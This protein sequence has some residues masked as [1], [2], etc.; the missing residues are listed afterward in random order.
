MMSLKSTIKKL[1]KKSQKFIEE[2][3]QLV[4]WLFFFSKNDCVIMIII[5]G[6]SIFDQT[7]H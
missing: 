3:N 2:T 6:I 7:K 1:E 4:V 5:K